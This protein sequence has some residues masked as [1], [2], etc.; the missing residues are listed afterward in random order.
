MDLTYSGTGS[1]QYRK[2]LGNAVGVRGFAVIAARREFNE[3]N[4][5]GGVCYRSRGSRLV[6]CIVESE[7][8]VV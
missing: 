6:Q 3:R 5:V 7:T 2:R 4:A 1:A 8:M